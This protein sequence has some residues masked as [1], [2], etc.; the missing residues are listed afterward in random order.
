MNYCVATIKPWNIR[1][2]EKF[3]GNNSQWY[4]ITSPEEYDVIKEL[5]PRYVFLPHWSW[6]VPKE[7]YESVECVGFHEGDLPNERGGSPIQNR[8]LDGVYH[9][10]IT[11]FRIDGGIDT[12]G[13]Y[14]NRYTCL[15][16]GGE[17]VYMR[18]ADV[19]FDDM[20]PYIVDNNPTPVPQEGTGTIFKRRKPEESEIN[21]PMSLRQLH[22]FIRMLD[23]ETYPKAFIR[24]GNLR[25]E[26][27]RSSLKFDH[28]AADV[29]IEE[30]K[31]EDE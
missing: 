25:L 24:Y 29:R 27:S 22:D 17:E 5:K 15:N 9:T 18:I 23:A 26:F 4:L 2:F 3:F 12:G 31:G 16:G 30:I 19:V 11:A 1:N 6:I 14:L 7:I 21:H 28:L 10:K 13:I 20:I 8:I